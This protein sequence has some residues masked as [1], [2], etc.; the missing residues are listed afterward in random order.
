MG[1]NVKRLNFE[2]QKEELFYVR[3]MLKRDI[4]GILALQ[5]QVLRGSGFDPQWFYP[6]TEEE[7]MEFIEEEAGLSVGMFAGEKLIAFRAGCFSGSEYDEITRALGSPYTEIPCF[8]LNGAFVHNAYRGNNL[9]QKLTEHC[10]ERCRKIGI[11]IFL[12]VV[13]PD[14]C[15]S[16]KSLYNI[17]F[18]AR[19]RQAIFQGKYDRIILVKE[20]F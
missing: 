6:F 9:Q 3:D 13:H 12:S 20:R 4:P 7:L 17:G 11:E 19:S 18:E 5:D 1:K 10:I 14:N 8:L 2:M 15:A 16:V